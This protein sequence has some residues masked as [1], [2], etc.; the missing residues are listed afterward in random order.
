MYEIYS[1]IYFKTSPQQCRHFSIPHT[2]S[3]ESKFCFHFQ[4]LFFYI[5]EF[6]WILIGFIYIDIILYRAPTLHSSKKCLFFRPISA[7][8]LIRGSRNVDISAATWLTRGTTAKGL[9]RREKLASF[10]HVE[11]RAARS[12]YVNG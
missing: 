11:T 10:R 4:P 7:A 2:D 1:R 6:L 8:R 3:P 12:R 9:E 5:Y